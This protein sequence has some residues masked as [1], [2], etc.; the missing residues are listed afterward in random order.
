MSGT[1]F[2][3]AVNKTEIAPD[4][5]E[6]SSIPIK[7]DM[8]VDLDVTA[9]SFSYDATTG[10]EKAIITSSAT[11]VNNA[12]L[13]GQ[14]VVGAIGADYTTTPLFHPLAK[15]KELPFDHYQ[16]M[17]FDIDTTK[18][19]VPVPAGGITIVLRCETRG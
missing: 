11:G 16:E 17:F 3:S 10:V 15:G 8:N 9:F 2:I 18:M 7:N 5:I 14:A 4:T 12:L 1:Y 13:R 6:T 19:S